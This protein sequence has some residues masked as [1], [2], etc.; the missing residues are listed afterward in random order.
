MKQVIIF[1]FWGTLVENG[2]L[3]PLKQVKYALGLDDMPYAEFVVRLE[4]AAMTSTASSIADMFEKIFREFGSKPL[5]NQMDYLV[6]LWNKNWLMAQVYPEVI[7]V[8]EELKNTSRLVLISNTDSI[9]V[10]SVMEKFKLEKYFDL[11]LLSCETGLLK[12]DAELYQKIFDGLHVS[13]ADC[14]AVGDSIETDMEAARQANVDAVLIDRR[15]K[16]QFNPRIK[17]LQELVWK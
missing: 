12:N 13:P 15:N 1:D 17:D 5:P 8:L 3:T 10:K 11:I 9:S 16:R 2:V 7:K 6:G 4:R 14:L